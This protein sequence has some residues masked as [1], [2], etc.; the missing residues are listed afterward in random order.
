MFVRAYRYSLIWSC[1]S[2]YQIQQHFQKKKSIFRSLPERSN[3]IKN[4]EYRK[5]RFLRLRFNR[6]LINRKKNQQHWEPESW[7][8]WAL[9]SFN[10][11]I[12]DIMWFK[13]LHKSQA[14]N[15]VLKWLYMIKHN[16]AYNS[17][18]TNFATITLNDHCMEYR[19]L[20]FSSWKICNRDLSW[21][22]R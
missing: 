4:S 13:S 9:S 10:L 14:Q 5:N 12:H 22:S 18:S 20:I 11:T 1:N 6:W 7:V 21:P 8:T 15:N 16:Q 17:M 2:K 19:D 3:M